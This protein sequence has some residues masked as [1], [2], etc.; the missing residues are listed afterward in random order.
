MSHALTSQQKCFPSQ[1]W[2]ALAAVVKV[3]RGVLASCSIH[4]VLPGTPAQPSAF[5]GSKT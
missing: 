3:P 1:L 5:F 4:M 2:F